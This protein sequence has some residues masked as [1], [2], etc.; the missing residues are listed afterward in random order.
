MI[1]APGNRKN[2]NCW[3]WGYFSNRIVNV[4]LLLLLIYNGYIKAN[5]HKYDSHHHNNIMKVVQRE[6]PTRPIQMPRLSGANKFL[7]CANSTILLL[8]ALLLLFGTRHIF[9]ILKTTICSYIKNLPLEQESVEWSTSSW[10]RFWFSSSG[11][12]IRSTYRKRDKIYTIFRPNW[13]H[14]SQLL[15]LIG[16]STTCL[17]QVVLP[18]D[19]IKIAK[20]VIRI[21]G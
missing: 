5:I 9:I 2:R 19:R 1:L 11:T 17:L 13:E 21:V 18:V 8:F 16:N 6:E 20:S 12:L 7:C 15:V 4:T 3:G 14:F 10:T